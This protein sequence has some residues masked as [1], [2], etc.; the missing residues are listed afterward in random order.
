MRRALLA[1][2]AALALAPA[3]AA[4]QHGGHGERRDRGGPQGLLTRYVPIIPRIM[5]SSTWQ[6]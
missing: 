5:W 3:T 4:A 1:A 2:L 6:W